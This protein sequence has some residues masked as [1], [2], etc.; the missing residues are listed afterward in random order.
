MDE[1]FDTGDIAAQAAVELPDGISG[2][3]ADTLCLN[4]AANA[5]L[6]C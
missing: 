3:E 1:R 6:K 5:S 2:E 4:M